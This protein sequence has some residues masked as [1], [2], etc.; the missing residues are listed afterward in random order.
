MRILDLIKRYLS[1]VKPDG[2]G[3]AWWRV[4]SACGHS[5]SECPTNYVSDTYKYKLPVCGFQNF[6]LRLEA[7]GDGSLEG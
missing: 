2:L 6:G 4:R 3:K 5:D 7:I 1:I